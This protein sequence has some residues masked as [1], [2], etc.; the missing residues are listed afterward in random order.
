MKPKETQRIGSP[1]GATRIGGFRG[2]DPLRHLR[3]LTAA[4]RDTGPD[5]LAAGADGASGSGS[6]SIRGRTIGLTLWKLRP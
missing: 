5:A 2:P 6:A 1:A 3:S 4:I